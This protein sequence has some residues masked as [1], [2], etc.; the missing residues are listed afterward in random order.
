[1]SNNI[2]AADKGG[3]AVCSLAEK[4][5]Q[6]ARTLRWERSPRPLGLELRPVFCQW[7][8]ILVGENGHCGPGPVQALLRGAARRLLIGLAVGL[9]LATC[10]TP[11]DCS[12]TTPKPVE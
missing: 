6:A 7:G 9:V 12:A 4:S 1:M 2:D 11:V 3:F 8:G 10:G 5:G